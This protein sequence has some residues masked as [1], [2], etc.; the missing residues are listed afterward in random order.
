MNVLNRVMSQ[1][2]ALMAPQ[3]IFAK[4]QNRIIGHNGLL[5]PVMQ[6]Y[7]DS[8]NAAWEQAI[9]NTILHGVRIN[10][11]GNGEVKEAID[12]MQTIVLGES[13]IGQILGESLH[14]KFPFQLV[15]QYVAE[16]TPEFLQKYRNQDENDRFDYIYYDRFERDDQISTMRNNLKDQISSSVR[17]NRNQMITWMPAIDQHR[18]ASPCAQ[19]IRV[20]HEGDLDVSIS[21]DWRS[22]DLFTAWQI[23]LVGII[24]MLHREVI[25]PNGC[26]II[27]I[28]DRNDSLHIYNADIPAAIKVVR[29]G[30][31]C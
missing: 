6:F 15:D 29:G 14:P 25:D 18:A 3:K 9:S 12:T 23:N 16:F 27:R 1:L 22:R 7:S 4:H 20:R 11:G 10:F 30:K 24:G 8:F 17:S 26:N 2:K 5:P 21:I 13:A 19:R 31:I 28:V